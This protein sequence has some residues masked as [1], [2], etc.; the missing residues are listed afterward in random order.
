MVIPR[1]RNRNDATRIR[2]FLED[3]LEFEHISDKKWGFFIYHTWYYDSP[4]RRNQFMSRLMEFAHVNLLN[5]SIDS[6]GDGAAIIDYLEWNIQEDPAMERCSVDD[7]IWL[8]CWLSICEMDL[9]HD[10]RWL[11]TI[12]LAL[13]VGDTLSSLI[14]NPL[15]L[16][17]LDRHWEPGTRRITTTQPHMLSW[18][19][20]GG[21][22]A[23]RKRRWRSVISRLMGVRCVI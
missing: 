1:M 12:S 2:E 20:H 6:E 23:R 11:V 9:T 15:I 8:A 19:I 3:L 14:R 16:F 21:G 22:T 5:S 4:E 18:C 17:L 10:Y 7:V 13:S